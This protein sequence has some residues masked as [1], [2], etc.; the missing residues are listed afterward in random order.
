MIYIGEKRKRRGGAAR[1]GVGI[2]KRRKIAGKEILFK[3]TFSTLSVEEGTRAEG[4]DSGKKV[5]KCT[6][7]EEGDCSQ[8]SARYA[9]CY[10]FFLL[11]WYSRLHSLEILWLF[12]G[13]CSCWLEWTL[14]AIYLG[15]WIEISFKLALLWLCSWFLWFF[16]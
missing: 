5:E 16:L 6:R 3:K 14:R 8:G 2:G 4:G 1:I 11:F 13:S 9:S 12:S 10:F 15:C 7:A